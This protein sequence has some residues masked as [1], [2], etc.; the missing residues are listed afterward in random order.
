MEW[1]ST[2]FSNVCEIIMGQ[3]PPG[4]TYNENGEGLPFF[5]G[6]AEFGEKYPIAKKWCTQPSK[7]AEDGDILLSVRAP[8]GPINIAPY[9]CVIGR[10]LSA[11]R[12]KEKKLDQQF[13]YYYLK[14]IEPSFS[15]TGQGSTFFAIGRNDIEKLSIP[16]P[17]LSEQ[18]RIVEILDQA[19]EIRKLRKQADE[20]AEKIIPALFYKMF[21]DPIELMKGDNS[22]ALSEFNIEFQNGFA[23]GEKDIVDGTPHLRMNNIDDLGILNLDL[24]RTVPN[25]FDKERY[26]LN[27]G[28]VI[29]M[30]TNSDDKI[31]KSCVFNIEEDRHFLFSNHLIRLR[32][33][34]DRISP[35]YLSTYLHLL[36]AKRFYPS[37]AKRWVNQSTISLQN[38]KNIKVFVPFKEKLNK[39]TDAI[40]NLN[41]NRK[42]RNN[43]LSVINS[44]FN[45]LLSKAFDGSL[46]SSWREAHMKELL[47][48]MEEQ[49]KYLEQVK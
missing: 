49:K 36:W 31:G 21:G 16:L 34:D 32:I 12:A 17:T 29:F 23:C 41:D 28:D 5:Q 3:S 15:K 30:S 35:E 13:L 14:Y 4:S 39:L 45:N 10:G 6:K 43:S 11:L 33:F 42:F 19:D 44:L 24:V 1:I 20:K 40:K 37:I 47:K 48:E 7:I 46:T 27:N 25:S 22:I 18:R 38:L 9:K 2:S 8:V 26:R